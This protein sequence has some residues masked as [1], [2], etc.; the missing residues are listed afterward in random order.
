MLRDST[1]PL[2]LALG[3]M[4]LAGAAAAVHQLSLSAADSDRL[5]SITTQDL[6]A[7]GATTA[8]DPDA[9]RGFGLPAFP[10]PAPD[11]A[12]RS[13]GIVAGDPVRKQGGASPWT[14]A[15]I[16]DLSISGEYTYDAQREYVWRV[17]SIRFLLADEGA[18][19]VFKRSSA[20]FSYI[21]SG[22]PPYSLE[23]LGPIEGPL[24]AWTTM[25]GCYVQDTS[26]TFN[27]SITVRLRRGIATTGFWQTL[28]EVSCTT[29][30]SSSDLFE[31]SIDPPGDFLF[32]DD[33]LWWFSVAWSP[34]TTGDSLRLYSC[35]LNYRVDTIHP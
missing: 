24:G 30:G 27:A 13:E 15:A 35:F 34:E 29:S 31:C 2:V 12:S 19:D 20:G 23:L 10:V 32:H 6:T 8:V 26:V 14:V 21:G 17:S 25:F 16:G 5:E 7:G 9:E 33:D 28:S 11:G 4:Q 3:C 1:A 22:S 18:D